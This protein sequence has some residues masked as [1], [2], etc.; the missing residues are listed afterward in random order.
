MIDLPR[1]LPGGRK[2]ACLFTLPELTLRTLVWNMSKWKQEE[3][4]KIEFVKAFQR[5]SGKGK[6]KK[7]YVEI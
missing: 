3:R 4:G 7:I 1:A 5:L 6:I 2:G